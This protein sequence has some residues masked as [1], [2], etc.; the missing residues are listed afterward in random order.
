MQHYSGRSSFAEKVLFSK[1]KKE[2]KKKR[3]L[4]STS[5]S[6]SHC[7]RC[8]LR[9]FSAA[10]AREA[11]EAALR[12]ASRFSALLAAASR[13][14]CSIH[15]NCSTSR[16]KSQI[17]QPCDPGLRRS[18]ALPE[19]SWVDIQLSGAPTTS[20]DEWGFFWHHRQGVIRHAVGYSCRHDSA[21]QSFAF[22]SWLRYD[23][24]AS[25]PLHLWC[26][27][28]IEIVQFNPVV[29]YGK[30]FIQNLWRSKIAR[31][32]QFTA[33]LER[34]V[35]N[36][37]KSPCQPLDCD[38]SPTRHF[39]VSSHTSTG[40]ILWCLCP[41]VRSSHLSAFHIVTRYCRTFGLFQNATRTDCK[42]CFEAPTLTI[43]RLEL[44]AKIATLFCLAESATSPTHGQQCNDTHTNDFLLFCLGTWHRSFSACN[45]FWMCSN[46]GLLLHLCHCRSLKS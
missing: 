40:H 22:C 16:T 15:G 30:I 46:F 29:F 23:Q 35:A 10:A 33:A 18:S 28:S 4:T 26:V 27:R 8:S 41:H 39:A 7:K 14:C 43:P 34:H 36:R 44:L 12:V 21:L 31:D 6:F 45:T 1:K 2:R 19:S 3:D 37:G 9:F 25:S 32:D 20:T 13:F 11:R 38:H 17:L 24:A 5:H 42:T